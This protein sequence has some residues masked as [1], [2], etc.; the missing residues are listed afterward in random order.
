MYAIQQYYYWS[1]RT[2]VSVMLNW[3]GSLHFKHSSPA[4]FL[5][6]Q[7]SS[8]ICALVHTVLTTLGCSNNR[9]H[10]THRFSH[11]RTPNTDHPL[12]ASIYAWFER[13][14]V[15]W[16]L[17]ITASQT[18]NI[19]LLQIYVPVSEVVTRWDTLYTVSGSVRKWQSVNLIV[20]FTVELSS[21]SY[22]S[23][24]IGYGC[25]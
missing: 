8:P 10:P 1:K 13:T 2:T 25:R 6:L 15:H 9:N 19:L 5:F 4:D 22:R 7:E 17:F 11:E 24:C 23:G 14:T 16:H 3:G 12:L 20:Y 21:N 18:P